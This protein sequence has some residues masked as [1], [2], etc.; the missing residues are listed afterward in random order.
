MIV[1]N[2]AQHLKKYME[3]LY[4]HKNGGRNGQKNGDKSL[5]HGN[6]IVLLYSLRLEIGMLENLIQKPGEMEKVSALTKMELFMSVN[7][8]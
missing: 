8:E 5:H 3:E 7:G 1:G 2:L 4:K 6:L